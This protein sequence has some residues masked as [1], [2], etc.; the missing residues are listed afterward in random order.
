MTTGTA[1]VVE[2]GF[3]MNGNKLSYC[4]N[5]GCVISKVRYD[6]YRGLC[7]RCQ[8]IKDGFKENYNN[9]L[10]ERIINLNMKEFSRFFNI[11]NIN[12]KEFKN[13]LVKRILLEG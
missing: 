1:P 6:D 8:R 12:K 5:C 10:R 7:K 2:V 13:L 9:E 11:N 4:K 3:R